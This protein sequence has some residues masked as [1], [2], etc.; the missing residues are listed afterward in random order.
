MNSAVTLP[1]TSALSYWVQYS[2]QD[3]L[4][5]NFHTYFPSPFHRAPHVFISLLNLFASHNHVFTHC[6][7]E[8]TCIL[9]LFVCLL[10]LFSEV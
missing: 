5:K 9:K 8:K 10:L 6:F 7:H 2:L 4:C 1:A 3:T